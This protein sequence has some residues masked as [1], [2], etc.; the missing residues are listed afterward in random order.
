MQ[1]P[2][3]PPIKL[4]ADEYRNQH[5]RRLS[6]MPWLYFS[7]KP[8][9]RLWADL[10]QQQLQQHLASVETV[11]IA[12]NCFIAPEAS[13]F[14]EPGRTITLDL[15]VSIA[16]ESFLHGPIKIG[17][18][19]SINHHCSFDG[20]RKGVVIGANTRIGPHCSIYGFNHR[21]SLESP[22]HQQSVQSQGISIGDDVWLGARVGVCDGV[23]IGNHAVIGMHSVVTQDIPEYAIAAG[24]P[25]RII[26]DRREH[27]LAESPGL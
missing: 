9:H 12:E 27:H 1:S 18:N 16:A 23:T 13:L 5:K 22:I 3:K 10:W 8:K 2:D 7:L 11:R 21:M 26:G 15:G 20:G 19:S 24:N 14:A 6:Y 17:A 4:S 25:A